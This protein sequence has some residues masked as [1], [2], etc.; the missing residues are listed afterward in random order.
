MNDKVQ[1][2]TG[3]PEHA[4]LL[5][6]RAELLHAQ[7]QYAESI[8]E[9]RRALKEGPNDFAANNVAMLIAL[10]SPKDVDEAIRLITRVID[11]RGP[12]ST[13]LDTRAVCYIV[14]G[15]EATEKAVEDLKM[16][17]LQQARAVYSYHLAWAYELQQ[18]RPERDKMLDEAKRIGL[19]IH[20]LHPLERE[21]YHKLY[22]PNAK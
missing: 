4:G 11:L 7:D 15:G 6:A 16:A 13:Y 3:K 20:D 9:Y 19:D 18:K 21:I 17:R 22:G 14:K 1:Q 8:A 5:A 12:V 10:Y 2:Y